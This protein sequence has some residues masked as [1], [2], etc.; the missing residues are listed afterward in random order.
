M[1]TTM[2]G[3]PLAGSSHRPR[4]AVPHYLHC[5]RTCTEFNQSWADHGQESHWQSG[6][7]QRTVSWVLTGRHIEEFPCLHHRRRHASWQRNH[8]Q[9]RPGL[10]HRRS[11]QAYLLGGDAGGNRRVRADEP[12]S[13]RRSIHASQKEAHGAIRNHPT[14]L[15]EMADIRRLSTVAT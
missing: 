1:L 6:G 10:S 9:S 4:D 12:R 2:V 11:S 3:P 5:D 8:K 13:V 15:P 14:K 7:C